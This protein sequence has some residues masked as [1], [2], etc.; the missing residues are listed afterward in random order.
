MINLPNEEELIRRAK[1][2]NRE[3]FD[4][5]YQHYK[6]PILNY[7]YRFIGN[8]SSAEELAQEV[9]VRAYMNIK[10][11]VPKAKFSSWLFTIAG[12]LAKNF[13]R[14]AYYERRLI[15]LRQGRYKGD[16]EESDLIANIEDKAKRPDE[17]AQAA[18]AGEIVQK[19]IDQLPAHLKEAL[20]LCDIEGFSYEEAAG[21]MCCKAM[22][23]GSRLWRARKKLASLLDYIKNGV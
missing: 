19:A 5:L 7:I 4:E 3:A 6:R 2:G 13:L 16:E 22:T 17:S 8:S 12:N 18:E 9:F 11:F 23:A 20:I 14:H 15:P 1:K 10:R 21:I